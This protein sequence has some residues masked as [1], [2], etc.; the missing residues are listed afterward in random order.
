MD[1]SVEMARL[2]SADG[3]THIVCSPH[4]NGTYEFDPRVNAAKTDELRDR[5]ADQNDTAQPRSADATST[6]PSTM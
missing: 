5:L 2:A 3:I 4:A 1:T 6:S